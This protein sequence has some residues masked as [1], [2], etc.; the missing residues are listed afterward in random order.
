MNLRT[1]KKLLV[2]GVVFLTLVYVSSILSLGARLLPGSSLF[3]AIPRIVFEI[4]LIAAPFFVMWQL[5]VKPLCDFKALDI[6]K[7]KK[8]FDGKDPDHVKAVL[9][10][11]DVIAGSPACTDDERAELT[12]G[13]VARIEKALQAFFDKRNEASKKIAVKMATMA[14]VMVM[15]SGSSMKDALTMLYWKGRM[16]YETIKCYGVRPELDDMSRIYLYVVGGAFVAG[17]IEEMSEIVDVGSVFG[18]GAGV[19]TKVITLPIQGTYA[20][21]SILRSSE[22][23][24]QYIR[25]G[26]A[27]SEER[28][29]AIQCANKFALENFKSVF[30]SENIKVIADGVSKHAMEIVGTF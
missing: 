28:R 19:F 17:S 5:L 2:A 20:V 22:L 26:I 13:N 25:N 1:V 15:L 12:S 10:V 9:S 27:E 21:W 16:V 24:R 4:A 3:I 14:A 29:K 6:D 30:N 23:T 11:A 8:A 7:V 18:K